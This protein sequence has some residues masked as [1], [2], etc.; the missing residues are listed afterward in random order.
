MAIS[1]FVYFYLFHGLKRAAASAEEKQSAYKDLVFACIAGKKLVILPRRS[2]G[3]RTVKFVV[4]VVGDVGDRTMF[5]FFYF[6]DIY[7]LMK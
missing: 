2:P 7:V 4:V 1:N 3:H 5:I 6:R